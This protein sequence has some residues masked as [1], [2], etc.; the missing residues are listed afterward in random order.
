MTTRTPT[1]AVAMDLAPE[2]TTRNRPW[3]SRCD[4]SR[5]GPQRSR[6]VV[7]LVRVVLLALV[8]GQFAA[9][10]YSVLRS[11]AVSLQGELAIA[12]ET[13]R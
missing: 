13:T 1:S 6:R 11:G 7:S 8:L 5:T 9:G 3:R 2:P 10:L 12:A 4:V